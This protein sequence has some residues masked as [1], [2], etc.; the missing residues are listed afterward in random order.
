MLTCVEGNT[1]SIRQ[2]LQFSFNL[3]AEIF[4]NHCYHSSE[5]GEGARLVLQR[6][7]DQLKVL[8]QFVES[9]VCICFRASYFGIKQHVLL[10]N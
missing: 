1:L 4:D 3:H 10:I 6:C 9:N 2:V 8:G 5:L 7:L